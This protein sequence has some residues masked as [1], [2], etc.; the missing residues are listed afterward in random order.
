MDNREKQ[1]TVLIVDDTPD[2]IEVLRQT[3]RTEYTV[4]AALSGEK[5][6][7]IVQCAEPPDLILLDIMM[8]GMD[9]YEVCLEL[10][11]D[12]RTRRIPV[13]FVT[14][15]TEIEDEARGFQVGG[16]DYI[17]KPVSPPIVL[18]RVRTQLA[19]YD[20]RRELAGMVRERTEQ[21]HETRLR[22]VQTLGRAAEYKDEDT[23]LHVVRMAHYS[24]LPNVRLVVL[25]ALYRGGVGIARP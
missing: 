2:N 17:T 20:Q 9:G 11:A 7:S 13:I 16:V 15:M 6:L 5:G 14:A 8:P 3:L 22:I 10:K 19:L 1:Q 24:R 23:G 18:A 25:R 4:V 21:L 12:M